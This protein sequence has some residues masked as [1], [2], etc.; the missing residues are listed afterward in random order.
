MDPTLAS[1]EA[2]REFLA[3][4]PSAGEPVVLETER[5]LSLHF[6]ALATQSFMSLEEPD[7]LVLG[8]TKLMMA[9]LLMQPT[10]ARISMIG[11]GGGSLL[12]YCHRRLPGTKIVA[13]EIDPAVIALRERFQ[14]P[15]DDERL[16]IV[17]ADGA[18][19]VEG[20]QA[21]PDV[22]LVDGFLADG[23]PPALGSVS[24]YAACH[25]RLSDDGV[26]VA[27]FLECDRNIPRYLEA[28]DLVFGQ[29]FSVAKS[30]DGSN[31]A[32]FAWKGADELPPLTRLLERAR[33]LEAEHPLNLRAA[34]RQ[35]L[36]GRRF[37][38]DPSLWETL[39]D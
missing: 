27:N 1:F 4:F 21:R 34:A 9:F 38:T 22:I 5:A 8:Y 25:R 2:Y 18:E 17:C 28:I 12:K 3:R 7:K 20:T 35:L 19:Y 39:A 11:L 29:S 36:H 15:A 24:F 10:P 37:A 31:Y 33:E 16:E 30:S 26:L 32:L 13:V 6:D 23:M 14:I